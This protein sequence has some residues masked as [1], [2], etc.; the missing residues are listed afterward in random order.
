M[1]SPREVGEQET[2]QRARS[3]NPRR[4]HP[5]TLD[6][7]RAADLGPRERLSLERSGQG[8]ARRAPPG[9]ARGP[10]PPLTADFDLDLHAE[11]HG[12]SRR[13]CMSRGHRATRP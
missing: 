8:H 11:G 7:V 5:V 6:G 9:N 2:G 12:T 4:F 10:H 1:S 3:A 13:L